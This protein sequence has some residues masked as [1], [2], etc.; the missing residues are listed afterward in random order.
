MKK[1]VSQGTISHRTMLSRIKAQL[2]SGTVACVGASGAVYCEASSSVRV[3]AGDPVV[4]YVDDARFW[5]DWHFGTVSRREHD[6]RLSEAADAAIEA[7]L[8]RRYE[9][10]SLLAEES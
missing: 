10:V 7:I 6:R 1:E 5:T 2:G 3:I 8:Q 4:Y 9:N